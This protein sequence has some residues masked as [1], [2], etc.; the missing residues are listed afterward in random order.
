MAGTTGGIVEFVRPG[1]HA[2]F[3]AGAAVVGGNLVRLT[4]NRSVIPTASTAQTAVVG[5][6]LFTAA[7]GDPNLT[8]AAD[9]VYP[10]VAQGSIATGDDLTSGS[11]AGSAAALAAA[12]AAY[13]QAEANATRNIVGRA[14]ESISNTATG[15][16]KL[17]L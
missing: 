3:T 4:G 1:Q 7:N 2:T 10:L 17:M 8:V 16:A 15:R 5:V 6:A 12:G 11:V 14:Y 13:V 9:G